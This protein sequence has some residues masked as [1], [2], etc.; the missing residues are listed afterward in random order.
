LIPQDIEANGSVGVD[1]WVIDLC[2][3]ADFGRFKR[4]VRRK[5]D[6]EEED[7]SRIRRIALRMIRYEVVANRSDKS[8]DVP[9]P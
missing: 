5:H 2:R 7:S 4:V 1:V 3:E 8:L 6:G 9:D